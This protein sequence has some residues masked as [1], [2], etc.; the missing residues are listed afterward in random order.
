[1]TRRPRH[2]TRAFALALA[3]PLA[4]TAPAATAQEQSDAALTALV[5]DF[6]EAERAFDQKRLAALITDDYAEVSPIGELDL[7]AAFLGFY[8]ADKK[9]PAPAMTIGDTL[10]RRYGDAASIITSLSFERPSPDGQ[11]RTVSIRVGFLAVRSGGKWKLASAQYTPERP[12][13]AK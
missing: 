5:R 12:K 13:P 7:H 9:Q 11:P 3:A 6:V 8:A 1:M 4:L 2:M 10:V